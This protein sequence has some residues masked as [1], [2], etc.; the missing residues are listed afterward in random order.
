MAYGDDGPE[1]RLVGAFAE[2]TL[3]KCIGVLISLNK[4]KPA[5]STSCFQA[6]FSRAHPVKKRVKC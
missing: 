4:P 2:T 5:L 6:S 1:K 3:E